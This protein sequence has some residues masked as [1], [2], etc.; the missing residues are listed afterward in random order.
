MVMAA[1]GPQG[2]ALEKLIQDNRPLDRQP[3]FASTSIQVENGK[4]TPF[5]EGKWLH[6]SAPKD[7]AP[8][9]Y[10]IAKFKSRSVHT[11]LHN[12]KWIS[13]LDNLTSE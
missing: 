13:S 9:L 3:F 11:E 10:Q 7:L 5:W 8:S 4:N 1:L 6:G 2:E 12:Y